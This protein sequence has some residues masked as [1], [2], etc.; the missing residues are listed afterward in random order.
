M[1][2]LATGL[3]LHGLDAQSLW[4]DEGWSVHLAQLPW[5]QAL[6]LIGSPGH[7]HP[8]AYYLLLSG[9]VRLWGDSVPA[10]RGLSVLLGVLGVG[11]LYLLGRQLAGRRVGLL[12]AFLLALSPTHVIYSQETRMYALLMTTVTLLALLIA[13]LAAPQG[14]L[15]KAHWV[16]LCLVEILAIY[17]HYFAFFAVAALS[18]WYLIARL[19]PKRENAWPDILRWLAS[20]ALAALAFLPW[21]P[22]FFSRA[23]EHIAE[24]AS[25]PNALRFVWDTWTF[26]VGG[27]IALAGRNVVFSRL[28]LGLAVV[29]LAALLATIVRKPDWRRI[30]LPL[31]LMIIPL[32]LTFGLMQLRPGYH[33]RYVLAALPPL[34][35]L[36]AWAAVGLL[37]KGPA[38]RAGAIVLLA[39]WLGT[40]GYAT[41]VQSTDS[42]YDRDDA[43]ATASY[44]E[45]RLAPGSL[46]FVDVDDWALRYYVRVG[47]LSPLFLDV[48]LLGDDALPY[49]E[50]Q[51][52]GT[53]AALV[54]WHQGET[55]R[56]GVL[57]YALELAGAAAATVDLPGYSVTNY[58][59]DSAPPSPPWHEM[60]SQWHSLRLV[61]AA[62]ETQ[63]PA[64]EALT[65]AL[66]WESQAPL[67]A[68]AK[69]RLDLRDTQEHTVAQRDTLLL[70]A[71]GRGAEL[72]PPG[73]LVTTYHALSLGPGLPP[74]DYALGLRVYTPDQPEG[75]DLVD[76]A[77]APAGKDV[78]LANI[79]LSPSL[80]RT[81]RT[82]DRPSLGLAPRAVPAPVAPG[83][84]VVSAAVPAGPIRNGD[85]LDLLIEWH[86]VA[87]SALPDIRPTL[88]L[89]R[90]GTLLAE[91]YGG[92]A[93]D[94]YPTS[95][96]Q[97]G[98]TVLDW[99][100]IQ[101][102]V[103]VGSG[104]AELWLRAGDDPGVHLA[105]VTIEA[106][107]RLLTQ[108][109]TQHAAQG[110]LGDIV[111]LV[112][113][114]LGAELH[115]DQPVDLVLV[116]RVLK[117][118]DVDYAVFT[119]VLGADGQ[120]V[121]QHDG[122]PGTGHPEPGQR[123]SSGWIVS[124]YLQDE[125]HL[126]WLVP[127]YQGPATVEVGLYD[128]QTGIRLASADGDSRLVLAGGIIVRQHG[129]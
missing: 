57:N 73:Q 29:S 106:I 104:P 41:W 96:W 26:L 17:T 120:L 43:R 37:S 53:S 14:R 8:P 20:Q 48:A 86:Q 60:A 115:S 113:F 71:Q 107:D 95:W 70:D 116:W 11:A 93:D 97:S 42:Y 89:V 78:H 87:P 128:P 24:G 2:G 61:R 40:M 88:Q 15:S 74:L 49:I 85:Q 81:A 23:N 30:T 51:L 75:L 114:D 6:A 111:E 69:V 47:P 21:L 9:W 25:T 122:T 28:A 83:L 36:V 62:V 125:H 45:T 112:G 55:D 123:P 44:L 27:H 13:R 50:G 64:D 117:R 22:V 35:L 38:W 110:Q 76:S 124:E 108:P 77:G 39:A 3:R 52:Q 10:V 118:T 33:P 67:P 92:P 1:L 5:S 79:E 80:G 98:E 12:A 16:L 58:L 121:A 127:D 46:V 109:P 119:H 103:G 54:K 90:A 99:R 66:T 105:D 126:E 68:G 56:A 32:L 65:I 129:E 63:A 7:T 19:W 34:L 94:R 59:L 100:S 72:W 102:P 82:L 4:Y 91:Q 101:V 18:L 84:V 31:G